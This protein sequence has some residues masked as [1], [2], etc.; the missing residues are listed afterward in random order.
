MRFAL[1]LQPSLGILLNPGLWMSQKRHT[2][3]R[4]RDSGLLCLPLP[5]KIT[6]ES[7]YLK[8]K[9]LLKF[10]ELVD[11][12][13]HITEPQVDYYLSG[14][15]FYLFTSVVLQYRHFIGVE[16]LPSSSYASESE[17]HHEY[18]MLIHF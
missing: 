10:V 12:T 8:K 5:L 11:S 18:S 2:Y 13:S 4:P 15:L 9:K 6:D 1:Y 16:S 14:I 3:H 17:I 7:N